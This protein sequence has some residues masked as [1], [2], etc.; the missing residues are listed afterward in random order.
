M[1]SLNQD[2]AFFID[3]P[4]GFTLGSYTCDPEDIS[5]HIPNDLDDRLDIIFDDFCYDCDTDGIQVSGRLRIEFLD[6]LPAFS[7]QLHSQVDRLIKHLQENWFY[8]AGKLW[9]SAVKIAKLESGVQVTPN[10]YNTSDG[11]L[12]SHIKALSAS[13]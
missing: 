10:S 13:V 1:S 4:T 5:Y 12:G 2:R 8:E 9:V 6:D 3:D 7:T 11:V